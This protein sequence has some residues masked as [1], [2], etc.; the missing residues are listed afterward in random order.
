MDYSPQLRFMHKTFA[1]CRLQSLILHPDQRIDTRMDLGMRSLIGWE[2]D[3]EL[4]LMGGLHLLPPNTLHRM[5]DQFGFCYQYLRLSEETN[6]I[7]WIG[8]YFRREVTREELLESVDRYNI[9][10]HWVQQMAQFYSELPIVPDDSAIHA[11]ISTFCELIWGDSGQVHEIDLNRELSGKFNAIDYQGDPP[12]PEDIT[13]RMNTIQRRYTYENELMRAVTLG[14][15]QKGSNM[16]RHMNA[17]IFEQRN[18]DELRNQKNYCI[19][20]NTLLRKAAEQGGVHPIYLDQASSTFALRIEQTRNIRNIPDLMNDM[21]YTYCRLVNRHS[22][23]Q[24]SL[25]VQRIIAYIDTDLTADLSLK[26]LAEIQ[27]L[28]PGYL[29][30]LFKED[31]GQTVTQFVTQRRIRQ[32]IRLLNSTE[33]QVQTIARHCGIPDVNYFT[34]IFKKQVGKSPSEY[35]KTLKR[36]TTRA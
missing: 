27:N 8:P 17:L 31:T 33:L 21:F 1:A 18:P 32:A 35:R 20:M 3:Y 12:T 16:L 24:F 10:V 19:I 30:T 9:P 2:R 28:S 25:P 4:T 36:D 15:V 29:S 26:A 11:M 13:R 23:K 22:T 6:T 5:R 7:L 14:L 34:K